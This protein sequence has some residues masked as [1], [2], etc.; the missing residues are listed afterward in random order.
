M[1]KQ[2]MQTASLVSLEKPTVIRTLERAAESVSRVDRD[3]LGEVSR[4]FGLDAFF[5][6]LTRQ[7]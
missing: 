4:A 5:R 7:G 3:R 1:K 2:T 6:L